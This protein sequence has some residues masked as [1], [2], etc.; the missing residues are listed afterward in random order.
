MTRFVIRDMTQFCI[1]IGIFRIL[2]F[3]DYTKQSPNGGKHCAS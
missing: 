1:K 2:I 3:A